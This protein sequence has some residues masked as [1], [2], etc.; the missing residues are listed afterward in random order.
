MVKFKQGDLIQAFEN[1]EIDVLLHQENCEGLNYFSGFA[2]L[3]HQKYPE[4][5]KLHQHH[6]SQNDIFGTCLIHNIDSKTSSV[7]GYIVNMYSQYY[8]GQSSNKTFL[9]N[10]Y[11]ICDSFENRIIALKNCLKYI[12]CFFNRNIKIGLPL[13]ASGLATCKE[14]KKGLTDLEYFKKYILSIIE[15]EL[16]DFDVTVYYL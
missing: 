8:K 12:D 6:C 4:L 11:L 10:G 14:R 13:I 5:T 7:N 2:K 1:N 15:E 3:I 16:K 9:L